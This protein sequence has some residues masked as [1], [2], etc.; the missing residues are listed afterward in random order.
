MFAVA[1]AIGATPA[2]EPVGSGSMQWGLSFETNVPVGF[3]LSTIVPLPGTTSTVR[4]SV[5]TDT[6]V[7][8]GWPAFTP[9]PADFLAPFPLVGE[10]ARLSAWAPLPAIVALTFEIVAPQPFRATVPPA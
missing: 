2:G 6:I 7:P 1:G 9:P 4:G 5:V 3:V 10:K 8:S